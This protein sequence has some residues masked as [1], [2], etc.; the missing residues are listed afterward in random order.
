VEINPNI[1]PDI[2]LLNAARQGDQRAFSMLMDKYKESLQY[3]ILKIVKS[4]QDAEDLMI[5]SFAKA[6]DNLEKYTP[7]YAFSTWLYKIASNTSID[8]LRKK[9]IQ[10]VSI[11]ADDVFIADSLLYSSDETPEKRL[12][13]SQRIALLQDTVKKL[14]PAFMLVIELRYFKEK[15][16]EEISIELNIPI[17]TVKVQLYRAKKQLLEILKNDVGKF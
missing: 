2:E 6:F 8:F 10:Q 14:D 5:E 11:D 12:I 9:S 3:M 17:G 7:Q 13:R 4:P 1:P 16:Y 15:S